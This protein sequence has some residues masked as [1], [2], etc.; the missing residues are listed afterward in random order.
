MVPPATA[1]TAGLQQAVASSCGALAR[2]EGQAASLELI[3]ES[4]VELRRET[5]SHASTQ[6]TLLD[7]LNSLIT[8]VDALWSEQ[9]SLIRLSKVLNLQL[10][11]QIMKDEEFPA[12]TFMYS[13]SRAYSDT[14]TEVSV[15]LVR[16][17]LRNFIREYGVGIPDD[18]YIG[19]EDDA[20]REAFRSMLSIQIQRLTGCK[21]RFGKEMEGK[22][23]IWMIYRD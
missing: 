6:A 22:E 7:A 15:V 9:D 4:L 17:I 19:A 16:E 20:G 10:A 11:V 14:T 23:E 8:R 18:S 1:T 12:G 5:A 3:K 2:H 21:P 13:K